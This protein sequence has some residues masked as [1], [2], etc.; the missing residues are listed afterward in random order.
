M[1]RQ[2]LINTHFFHILRLLSPDSYHLSLQTQIL[3]IR[4]F[5]VQKYHSRS[6]SLNDQDIR[7]ANT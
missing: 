1:C 7:S 4:I 3:C 2:L 6:G 5:T